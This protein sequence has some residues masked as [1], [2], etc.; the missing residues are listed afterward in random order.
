MAMNQKSVRQNYFRI[1]SRLYDLASEFSIDELN[2][3]RE[4]FIERGNNSHAV[5]VGSLIDIHNNAAVGVEKVVPSSPST[6]E[7][8]AESQL[9]PKER[10]STNT[11]KRKLIAIRNLLMMSE[12]FKNISDIAGINSIH[13]KPKYKESREKYVKRVMSSYHNMST[14]DKKSFRK[15]I[16]DHV[17][18]KSSQSFVSKWS[19]LIKDL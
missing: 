13:L 5:V 4:A 18:K 19:S 7:L 16:A 17:A 6:S 10:Q 12:I 15:E 9:T 2:D 11:E 3:V 8:V 14:E 1:L